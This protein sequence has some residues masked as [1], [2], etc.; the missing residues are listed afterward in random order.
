MALSPFFRNTM[1][2]EKNAVLVIKQNSMIRFQKTS[3]WQYGSLCLGGC[4]SQTIFLYRWKTK[5]SRISDEVIID[6][7]VKDLEVSVLII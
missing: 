4:P 1:K 6:K 2:L 5:K 3:L 7:A